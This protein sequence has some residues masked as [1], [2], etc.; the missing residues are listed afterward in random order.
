MNWGKGIIIGMSLFMGFIIFLVVN[1]MAHKSDLVSED[2]YKNEINYEAELTALK[3]ND[4]LENQITMESQKDYVVVKIPSKSDFTNVELM[5]VRPDNVKLDRT[6]KI[7]GKKT[8][9]IPKKELIR[10]EYNFEL[11]FN[12]ADKLCLKK[13]KI[14]I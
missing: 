1:M 9:L 4:Q 6:F 10:G 14:Y 8:F 11:R 5:L 7:Q 3:N 12:S 13:D 2:Y